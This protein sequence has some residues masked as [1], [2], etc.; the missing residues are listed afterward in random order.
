MNPE[1][2]K[3]IDRSDEYLVVYTGNELDWIAKFDKTW[4]E[5]KRWADHMVEVYNSRL[6]HSE[7]PGH[8]R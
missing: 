3:V 8:F 1:R 4:V 2:L 6:S 7:E 5:A